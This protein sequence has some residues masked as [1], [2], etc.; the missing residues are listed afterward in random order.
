MS[1]RQY[2]NWSTNTE[3]RARKRAAPDYRQ[4]YPTLGGH[5][6][7]VS[8]ID[9][10]GEIDAGHQCCSALCVRCG[11]RAFFSLANDI[12]YSG[13]AHPHAPVGARAWHGWLNPIPAMRG[14]R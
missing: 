6:V 13:D 10:F 1:S 12:E 9:E 7:D 11:K 4:L 5:I 14:G 2:L 8:N 3:C